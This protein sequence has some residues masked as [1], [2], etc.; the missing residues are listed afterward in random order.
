[1]IHVRPVLGN[2]DSREKVSLVYVA[3]LLHMS[4]PGPRNEVFMEHRP[5]GALP[6]IDF[7]ITLL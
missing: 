5:T 6:Y 4:S 3:T 7:Q 2:P 1:M